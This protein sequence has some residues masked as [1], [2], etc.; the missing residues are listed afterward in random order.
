VMNELDDVGEISKSMDL[1]ND[2]LLALELSK[3]TSKTCEVVAADPDHSSEDTVRSEEPMIL[4]SD[5]VPEQGHITSCG[6]DGGCVV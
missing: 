3:E 4:G 2:E 1:V 5:A 6:P